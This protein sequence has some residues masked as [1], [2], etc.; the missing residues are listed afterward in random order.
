METCPLAS[1]PQ[2]NAEAERRRVVSAF[3]G[4]RVLLEDAA[5]PLLAR[6][7]ALERDAEQAQEETATALTT[8]ISRLDAAI[9]Q[10]EETRRQPAGAFLRVSGGGTR[11]RRRCRRPHIELPLPSLPPR[12]SGAP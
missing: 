4:L 10:L 6:L 2:E 3:D 1:A 8:E 7:G 5:R 9:R 12:T 11:P